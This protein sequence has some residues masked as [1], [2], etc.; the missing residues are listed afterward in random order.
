MINNFASWFGWVTEAS[1]CAMASTYFWS[2]PLG[3]IVSGSVVFSSFVR[4]SHRKGNQGFLD[5]I[6]HLCFGL[7]GAAGFIAGITEVHPQHIVKSVLVLMA[8]RG[9]IKAIRVFRT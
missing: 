5:A 1:D 3:L 4:V 2:T 8:I 9:V 7:T 6:W